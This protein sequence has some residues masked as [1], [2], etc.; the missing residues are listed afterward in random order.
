MYISTPILQGILNLNH[1]L[2]NKE[3]NGKYKDMKYH[4]PATVSV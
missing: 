3:H 1:S 4:E 2:I